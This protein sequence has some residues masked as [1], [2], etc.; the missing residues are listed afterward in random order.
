MLLVVVFPE[1]KGNLFFFPLA[2]LVLLASCYDHSSINVSL[3]DE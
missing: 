2:V 3:E 1:K